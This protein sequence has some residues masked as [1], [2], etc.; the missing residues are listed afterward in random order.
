[1]EAETLEEVGVAKNKGGRPRLATRAIRGSYVL[2]SKRVAKIRRA[3]GYPEG[4]ES[5]IVVYAKE[6]G[7]KWVDRL[8]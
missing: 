2:S 3:L 6:V 8:P 1:M 4:H 5:E 7:L